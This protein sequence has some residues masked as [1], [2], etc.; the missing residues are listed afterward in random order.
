ME[1]FIKDKK[2][3]LFQD[4][5]MQGECGVDDI[6]VDAPSSHNDTDLSALKV[7]LRVRCRDGYE[8]KI[9]LTKVV[10][11]QKS[12][13]KI[14]VNGVLTRLNGNVCMQ[15]SFENAAGSVI[16]ITEPFT[17]KINESVSGFAQ[18]ETE[19]TPT[20]YEQLVAQYNQAIED[21]QTK[22]EQKKQALQQDVVE[23]VTEEVNSILYTKEDKTSYKEVASGDFSSIDGSSVF[24]YDCA[25]A[26][27][28]T[29]FDMT[30][31]SGKKL[32]I[33][34]PSAYNK[35]TYKALI[36][37]T[38]DTQPAITIESGITWSGDEV[39][40]TFTPGAQSTYE[41]SFLFYG[42]T[43]SAVVRRV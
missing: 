38:T 2:V 8:D 26:K 15:I 41:I 10:K 6:Y 40:T 5:V 9:Q 34:T 42:T 7:Y 31:F 30:L 20:V 25:T 36:V 19:L 28:V 14:H 43:C 32:K 35:G 24:V 4:S 17:L 33:A 18:A 21:C 37:K 1:G 3:V 16:Y 11:N 39:T 23:N 22:L 29:Y 12:M 27:D 13:V